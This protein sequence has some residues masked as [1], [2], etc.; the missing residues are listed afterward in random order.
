M[1]RVSSTEECKIMLIENKT[2]AHTG[3]VK[4][5]ITKSISQQQQKIRH[6]FFSLGRSKMVNCV[7]LQLQHNILKHPLIQTITCRVAEAGF[8][9]KINFLRWN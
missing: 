4:S 1:H 9:V 7:W 5:D 6:C 2:T 3:D 8:V